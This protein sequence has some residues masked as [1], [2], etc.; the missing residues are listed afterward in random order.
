[1][2]YNLMKKYIL[3]IYNQGK[4]ITFIVGFTKKLGVFAWE[5]SFR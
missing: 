1:M 4:N 2:L 5:N 3:A